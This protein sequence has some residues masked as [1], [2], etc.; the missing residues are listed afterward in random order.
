M[1]LLICH[2]NKIAGPDATSSF[3]I[4]FT[5]DETQR[6]RFY[7]FVKD[8]RKG[9]E[10]LLMGYDAEH[11]E[12]EIKDLLQET[13][14]QTLIRLNRRMHGMINEIAKDKHLE[15]AKIKSDLKKFLVEREYIVDSTSELDV[16]G[17]AASI[18]YL[19]NEF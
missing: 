7:N 2:F 6:D 12:D 14:E 5:V 13:P 8:L 19:H 4:E 15:P 18:Y 11:E 3:K 17:F 1:K 16:K 9:N 10:L